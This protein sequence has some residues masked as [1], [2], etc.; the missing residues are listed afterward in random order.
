MSGIFVFDPIRN[1][2]NRLHANN[3]RYHLIGFSSLK[4]VAFNV[5]NIWYKLEY[6][7]NKFAYFGQNQ[8]INCISHFIAR[9]F[10]YAKYSKCSLK[11]I[12]IAFLFAYFCNIYDLISDLI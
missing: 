6:E 1:I 8:S 3:T 4:F 2:A 9:S 7:L 12:I 10:K 5:N 11:L